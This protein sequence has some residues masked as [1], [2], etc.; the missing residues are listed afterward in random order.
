MLL[1]SHCSRATTLTEWLDP[2][3][4]DED[5]PEQRDPELNLYDPNNPNQ[6]PY[7]QDFLK[8]FREKQI[9]RNNKITAWAKDKL[10]SFKGDPTKEFGF[11]VTVLWPIHD[12]WMQP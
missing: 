3:I 8:L 10:D 6:P 11:I 9:E 4:T 5:K 2:S 1:A 7:S 12:G